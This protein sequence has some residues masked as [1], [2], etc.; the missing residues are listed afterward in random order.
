MSWLPGISVVLFATL[1]IL[2]LL[3]APISVSLGLSTAITLAYANCFLD[4]GI[5]LVLVPQKM[6]TS[7]DSFPLMAIPF[8][9]IAGALM[10]YGGISKRLIMVAQSMI[11][12]FSGGLAIVTI[13]ASM[14]FAAI[15]GSSPATVAA[16]GSLM[17]P[18]MVKQGYDI[19]FAAAC[20]SSAGYIGVIIPPSIPMITYGVV[21]GSSIGSLFLAGF[22]PGILVGLGLMAVAFVTARRRGYAGASPTSLRAFLAALR[23]G[24]WAILMPVIILGG[25][26]A[27][28]FTPTEA[29]NVAVIYGFIVSFFVYRELKF[30]HIPKILRTAAISSA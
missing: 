18:A 8:F 1:I 22:I 26:Y 13:V 21:T 10:E 15:S 24:V 14:F 16:I 17:I 3:N 19:N 29:A 11:G 30:S 2:M 4:Y 5:S 25:I 28:F 27:G 9:M 7:I 6:V 20:Q 23:Q 12:A